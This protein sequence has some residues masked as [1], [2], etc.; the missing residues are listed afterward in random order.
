M[1]RRRVA[2]SAALVGL[3]AYLLVEALSVLF[4]TGLSTVLVEN[5]ALVV[6]ASVAYVVGAGGVYVAYVRYRD[7]PLNYAKLYLPDF[8]DVVWTVA[9]FVAMFGVLMT[10]SLVSQLV[11]D[12]EPAEHGLIQP[13]QEDPA[14]ALYL[15]PLVAVVVAPL[16]E[17]IYRGLVQTRLREVFDATSAVGLASFLFAVIHVAAYSALSESVLQTL[18]PLVLIFGV[19]VVMGGVYEKTGN[20]FVPVALHSFFNGLQMVVL[21]LN[22]VYDLGPA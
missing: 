7:L 18:V 9:G 8:E 22:V 1:S 10:V 16:E 13:V 2:A 3:A 11:L 21:Y 12:V 17:L 5:L 6:G 19:A 14:L 20:L 4:V 15:L